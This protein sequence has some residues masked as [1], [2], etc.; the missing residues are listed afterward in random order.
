MRHIDAVIA[1]NKEVGGTFFDSKTVLY[2]KDKVLPTL[3]GSTYFLSYTP[4]ENGTKLYT[5][6][7]VL[8]SGKIGS[9]GVYEGYA[10]KSKAVEAIRMLL[11]DTV[12][13]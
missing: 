2:F 13:A 8:S 12:T 7:K 4:L 1:K 10:S 9:G 5:I 6:R 11:N 3:Y